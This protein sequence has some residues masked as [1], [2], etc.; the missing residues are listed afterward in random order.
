MR[1][2]QVMMFGPRYVGKTSLLASMFYEYE[3][4]ITNI[5]IKP[6][7]ETN[8]ILKKKQ[9]ELKRLNDEFKED[10]SR[11]KREG[12]IEAS[13][14]KKSFVFDIAIKT[15]EPFLRLQFWDYR[16]DDAISNIDVSTAEKDS[17]GIEKLLKESKAVL[18]AIDAPALM[19][20][21]GK[22]HKNR[23]H[24]D[25]VIDKLQKVY[26]NTEDNLIIILVP[27]KCE[28]YM[29][30]EQSA[31]ELLN[32]IKEKY[33]K[34]LQLFKTKPNVAIVVTPVQTV[35]TLFFS[36]ID[37]ID[38]EP[39]FSFRK[40]NVDAKYQPKDTEKPLKY[41]LRFLFKYYLKYRMFGWLADIFGADKHLEEAVNDF[42]KNPKDRDGLEIIQGKNLL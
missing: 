30:N 18:L 4:E 3:K 39:K 21:E 23:N 17:Q 9:N 27:T 16:G 29:K 7:E 38:E 19:E 24:P 14:E 28:S 22:W 40:Q 34:L 42:A 2:F 11:E 20:E 35:G 33:D 26:K 15:K 10:I 36:K 31:Q 12:G 25:E 13:S 37:V 8:A 41:L 6:D 32:R 1:E 5:D